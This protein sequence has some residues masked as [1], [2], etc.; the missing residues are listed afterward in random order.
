MELSEEQK[1]QIEETMREVECPKAFECYKS[2]LARLGNIQGIG[3]SGFLEC[4]AEDSQ[5]CH[6]SLS[7]ENPSACL[8]PV[9]IYIAREFTK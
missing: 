9:R 3:S 8:C 2:G 6:F 4:L 1:S 5:N 7:F